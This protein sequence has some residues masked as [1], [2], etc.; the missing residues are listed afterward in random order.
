MRQRL[1]LIL[2]GVESVERTVKLY[3]ALE[4]KKSAAGS[5]EFVLFNLG[6]I[7]LGVQSRKAFAKDAGYAEQSCTGFP[8]FALAY[9][10]RSAEEVYKVMEKA[11]LLGAEIAKPAQATN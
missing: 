3:E 2:L 11:E 1:N 6:G 8:G 5:S 10:A 7:A 9:I 4:W